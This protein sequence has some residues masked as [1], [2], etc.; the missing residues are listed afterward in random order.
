MYKTQSFYDP[1]QCDSVIASMGVFIR[2][3]KDGREIV[4]ARSRKI[5]RNLGVGGSNLYS[6]SD[7][8]GGPTGN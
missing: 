5:N 8:T 7:Q 3:G 6:V 1:W 2:V 4:V